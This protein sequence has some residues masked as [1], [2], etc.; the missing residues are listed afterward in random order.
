MRPNLRRQPMIKLLDH[1]YVNFVES[2]GSDERIIEAARMSTNKGF[3]G[4]GPDKCEYCNGHGVHYEIPTDLHG[5]T[6]DVACTACDGPHK[7]GDEKLL[8]Y[9]YNNKH[10]TPFE[11]A[12]MVIEVQ[13]PIMVF[14]EW[15][16]HRTQSYNEMS[17]RYTELPDLYYIPDLDR[18]QNGKQS[19]ANKQS[20]EA[21]FSQKDAAE[22]SALMVAATHDAR[23]QYELLLERG[24]SRELARLILPVNQYSRMRASTN[25]R[26][27]LGFLELR[28]APGAQY[29]IRVYANAVATLIA[30]K[31]PRTYDLFMEGR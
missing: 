22:M 29:E 2:W 6:K 3:Q 4:W 19:T 26:N 28:M 25:L 1:G 17:G 11:M 30:E 14:R 5:V 8:A 23:E 27:W 16:R 24:L 31:F 9:L 18:L 15:H 21:G 13:A 7:P 20:S 10:M 12:G